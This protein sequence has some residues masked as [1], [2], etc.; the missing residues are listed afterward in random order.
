MAHMRL[1]KPD[2]GLC[3]NF[4]AR[5]TFLFAPSSLGGRIEG[6]AALEHFDGWPTRGSTV[7]TYEGS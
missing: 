2:C 3:F 5:K 7:E 6:P 1:S 4:K